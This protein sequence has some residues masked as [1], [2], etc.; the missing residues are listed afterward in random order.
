MAT[1]C[2]HP[3]PEVTQHSTATDLR[4]H[5]LS[6]FCCVH[7]WLVLAD[8]VPTLQQRYDCLVRAAHIDPGSIELQVKLLACRQA[9][10][11]YDQD[12]AAQLRQARA[13]QLVRT[14]RPHALRRREPPRSLGTILLNIGALSDIDPRSCCS[15]H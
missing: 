9:L 13:L 12:I 14:V 11:P 1:T 2:P 7:A 10:S 4:L 5:L 3:C 6:G 8:Q 15:I